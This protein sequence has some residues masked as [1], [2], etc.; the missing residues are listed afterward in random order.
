MIVIDA[1][2]C[3][4][5]GICMEVC[6][7][8]AIY[9]VG[10]KAEVDGA[11]CRGCQSCIAACPTAA[12]AFVYQEQAPLP[13]PVRA[14]AQRPASAVI[15][16]RAQTAPQ[17]I[18]IRM[19]PLVGAMLARAIREIVPRLADH[20]LDSLERRAARTSTQAAR[21]SST[22]SPASRGGSGRGRHHRRRHRGG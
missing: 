20:A 8:G 9:L 18:R 3:N 21:R 22:Q 14:P 13:E 10:E 11:L 17:A 12:I 15:P 19:L 7:E 5:C 6:P 4:G 16:L 2:R 1:T